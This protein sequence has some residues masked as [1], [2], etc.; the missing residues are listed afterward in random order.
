MSMKCIRVLFL[1]AHAPADFPS[2]ALC[3]PFMSSLRGVFSRVSGAGKGISEQTYRNSLW[4]GGAGLRAVGHCPQKQSFEGSQR[5][6]SEG[7]L[8]AAAFILTN[9]I[10]KN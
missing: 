10:T 5:A 1:A 4:G 3:E 9:L 7:N 2:M 6:V 8:R